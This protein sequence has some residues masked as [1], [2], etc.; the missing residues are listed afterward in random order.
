MK[1]TTI[2]ADEELLERLREVARRERVPLA[3]VIREGLEWRA[4]Q[5]AIGPGFIGAG[6]SSPP[7]DTA[8]RASEAPYEPRSWR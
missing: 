8:P 4:R 2:M 3:R 7:H 1:R 6:A 5:E